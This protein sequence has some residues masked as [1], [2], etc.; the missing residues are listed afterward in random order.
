MGDGFPCSPVLQALIEVKDKALPLFAL[1]PRPLH[2]GRRDVPDFLDALQ[3][4][5]GKRLQN[6]LQLHGAIRLLIL[7]VSGG[8]RCGTVRSL[9][10]IP[11]IRSGNYSLVA[12]GTSGDCKRSPVLCCRG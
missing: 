1:G 3:P 4:I 12:S 6:A 11:R 7:M 10:A 2:I 8:A 5:E 9:P